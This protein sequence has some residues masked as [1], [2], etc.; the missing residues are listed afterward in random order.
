MNTTATPDNT[1]HNTRR[2]PFGDRAWAGAAALLPTLAIYAPIASFGR[3]F[4]GI[5]FLAAGA[6][7]LAVL[8][9]VA[10]S[11]RRRRWALAIAAAAL[12]VE[13][14]L[15]MFIGGTDMGLQAAIIIVIPIAY[16]AAWGVA[17]RQHPRW[18]KVGLPLA[19][20]TVVAPIRIIGMEWLTDNR[21]PLLAG[22]ALS[23]GVVALG[24][25]IC[26]A[27]D[28][29]AGRTADRRGISAQ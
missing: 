14:S 3:D 27:V 22:W 13:A 20:I 26:W 25:L 17:R 19:A 29:R 24:C 28:R 16:I 18:W 1:Q 11:P 4:V 15:L 8:A 10:R 9:L 7:F 2:F 21:M 12:A 5:A 6:Y 23:P